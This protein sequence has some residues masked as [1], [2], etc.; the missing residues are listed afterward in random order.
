MCL[1][2]ASTFKSSI[3]LKSQSYSHPS[4]LTERVLVHIRLRTAA[5]LYAPMDIMALKKVG[6]IKI[7]GIGPENGKIAPDHDVVYSRVGQLFDKPSEIRMHFG[8]TPC[9]VHRMDPAL[10][11]GLQAIL[12]HLSC[13]HFFSVGSCIHMAVTTGLVTHVA[14]VQLKDFQT[15][16]L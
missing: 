1:E 13:H 3:W 4:Q 5:G 2:E 14:E 12:H 11:D 9:Q 15:S 10:P 16:R 8:S 7:F 6:E